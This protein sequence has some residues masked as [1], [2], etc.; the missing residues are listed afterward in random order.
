M[1]DAQAIGEWTVDSAV[2]LSKW[3]SNTLLAGLN[4]KQL[5]RKAPGMG[6]LRE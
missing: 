4:G 3:R 1:Q 2:D 6:R 5:K